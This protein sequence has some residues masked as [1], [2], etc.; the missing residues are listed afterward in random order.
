MAINRTDQDYSLFFK[1]LETYTPSGFQGIDRNDP[2]I[3]EL[4]EMME[5]NNQFI[6]VA[7]I[8]QMKVLFTSKRS[9]Q[10]IGIEPD[11]V[12]PY[13]FMEVTHPDDLQRLN[14]GRAKIIK[15][16]QELFIVR[17]G[18]ALFSTNFKMH[19][20]SGVYSNFLI[21]SYIYCSSIPYRTVFFLK[22]H[23]NIDNHKKIKFGYHYYIGN[24]L[25]NF[26][27]PDDE[28]LSIGHNF[29]DREFEIIKLIESGM[30]TEQIAEKLFISPYTVNTHR[31][32]ILK[33]TGKAHIF[34]LINE[35]QE[36][37]IL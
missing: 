8:I 10:M 7:D 33:K 36:R 6:Y 37:G 34:E 12:S 17:E 18:D 20:P 27:Y 16:A 25:G 15:M 26:K 13:H 3:I 2:L 28:L 22:I 30:S 29:S 32:N 5:E 23:T 4:E 9:I 21:Q 14:R 11:E 35:L 19:T 1:F 31:G 24:D